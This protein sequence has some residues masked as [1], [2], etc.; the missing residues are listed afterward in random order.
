MKKELSVRPIKKK[1]TL[2]QFKNKT[3]FGVYIF[4]DFGVL[5]TW[6]LGRVRAPRCL[7]GEPC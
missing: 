6:R 1:M 7:G 4:F 5:H 3:G 2:V